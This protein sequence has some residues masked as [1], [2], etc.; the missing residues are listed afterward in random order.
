MVFVICQN[1][2]INLFNL[3]PYN[4]GTITIPSEEIETLLSLLL[5][6]LF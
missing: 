6:L 3:T 1:A 2:H 5:L 4:V